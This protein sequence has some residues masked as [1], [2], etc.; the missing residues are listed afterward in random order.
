MLTAAQIMVL[1]HPLYASLV[2]FCGSNPVTK[3][4]ARAFLKKYPQY[5]RM[6]TAM[7][8]RTIKSEWVAMVNA[9]NLELAA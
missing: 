2:D 5:Q 8:A 6:M 3:R 4:K 7:G 9:S 1:G